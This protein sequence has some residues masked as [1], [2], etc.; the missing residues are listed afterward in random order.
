M[1]QK[2][3]DAKQS[4]SKSKVKSELA[5]IKENMRKTWFD[6]DRFD[7]SRIKPQRR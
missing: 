5:V 1:F 2:S 6:P 4:V 3:V 7:T